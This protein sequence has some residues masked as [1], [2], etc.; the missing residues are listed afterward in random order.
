M[1]N[2]L[3]FGNTH[4]HISHKHTASIAHLNSTALY[5]DQEIHPTRYCETVRY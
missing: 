2:Y 5:S 4:T 3:D 1:K